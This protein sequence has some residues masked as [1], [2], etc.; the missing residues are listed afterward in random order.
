MNNIIGAVQAQWEAA[1]L[2]AVLIPFL[3]LGLVTIADRIL[4]S[5]AAWVQTAQSELV[6]DYISGLV[7]AQAVQLDMTYY[8]QNEYYDLIHRVRQQ[9]TNR[10]LMLLNSTGSLVQ[11]IFSMIGLAALLIAY[12]AWLLPL[13]VISALPAL[14][15]LIRFNRRMDH[16]RKA[17]T[18]RE[19]LGFYYDFLLTERVPASEMRLFSLG[20]H[21]RNGYRTIR[22]ELRAER[23]RLLKSK[24]LIDL[25]VAI[26]SMGVAVGVMVWMGWRV[27]VGTASLGDLAALYQIFTQVQSALGA[28]T[29][30]AGDIYESVLFLD[31]L[32]VFL[33]LKP[34]IQ[35]KDEGTLPPLEQEIRFENVS[36]RYPGSERNAIS[37]F[38]T[39][40][41]AGKIVAL[42]GENGEGKTTMM[43]L[44]CRFFDP[45]QGRILWDGIDLRD[46]PVASLR[47]QITMLF[48]IPTTT[49]KPRIIILLLGISGRIW[50]ARMSRLPPMLR[51]P[52]R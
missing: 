9:A 47:R 34:L 8:E 15:S 25:F 43:K 13:L 14:W 46:V 51:L 36:F 33:D 21:Y 3:L 24:V 17:S 27:V 2:Q 52:T 44:L 12:G 16:W 48:Q 7:Q 38:S 49:R 32:F 5:I 28:I 50:F 45:S 37:E 30:R 42:V 26:L 29:G 6:R 22:N 39:V 1:Q 11:S 35:D 10:P 18:F 41:P 23:L 40:L 19:Q 4:T 20:D 31:D